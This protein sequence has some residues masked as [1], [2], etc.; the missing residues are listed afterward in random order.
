MSLP[1]PRL[2]ALPDLPPI[3]LQERSGVGLPMLLIHGFTDCR[4]S[5]AL[6][7]PHLPNPLL[8]PDLPGHGGSPPLAV[9][10]LEAMADTLALM[11]AQIKAGPVIAVGHS[12]GAL[13]ALLLTQRH[14]G[15]AQGLVLISGSLRPDGP[16]FAALAARIN[17]LPDPL[18]PDDPFFADWHS[19]ARPV[20]RAV[21]DTLAESA[22]AMRRADWLDCLAALRRADLTALA[23]RVTCPVTLVAGEIDPIFPPSHAKALACALPQARLHLMPGLGHNP[24]WEAPEAVA[25]LLR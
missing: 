8:I 5:Y 19:C 3:N 18:T 10:T 1:D 4:A 16:E 25:E 12:M 24:H 11:L 13:V 6:M 14:P 17:A 22:A 21:L 7:A 9:M 20:P 15:L 2:V 23:A